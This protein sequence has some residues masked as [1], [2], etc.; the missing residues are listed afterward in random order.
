MCAGMDYNIYIWFF[1][2]LPHS[3]ET[4]ETFSAV[5][6]LNFSPCGN[7]KSLEKGSFTSCF[8]TYKGNKKW[9]QNFCRELE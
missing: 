3:I 1:L 2:S 9:A 7:R 4:R 8:V 5:S 6:S